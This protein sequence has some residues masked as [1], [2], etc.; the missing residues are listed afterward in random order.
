MNQSKI[1]VR[2]AKAFFEVAQEKNLIEDIN[3]EIQLVLA[4]CKEKEFM[5]LLESQVVKT[6]RK[7]ELIKQIFSDHVHELTLKFLIMVTENRREAYVPDIFRNYIAHYQKHKGIK[8][9]TFTTAVS[10]T[11]EIKNQVKE[12]I[13]RLFKTEVELATA[14]NPEL[15]G[16][17]ILRVGD[18]Q[19]DASVAS[20]L[21]KIKRK[22]LNTP[23]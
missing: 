6:S 7:K 23:V 11:S 2:Y 8:T 22:F 15:I 4:T 13:A 19:I 14:E 9:A 18:E 17:F 20:K 3:K 21:E 10:L 12:T 5:L 16:G 1:A